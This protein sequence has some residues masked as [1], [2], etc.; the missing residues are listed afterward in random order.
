MKVLIGNGNQEF[1]KL[2]RDKF[3]DVT[4]EAGGSK[5]E[6]IEQVR[7]AD[8]YFGMPLREVFVA[9]E[10]LRWVQNPG[11][12]IDRMAKVPEMVDSDVVLTNCRGPHADPMADHVIGMMLGLT[13]RFG[14]LWD[15]QKAHRWDPGKYGSTYVELS[16]R[17][18]GI[19]A[20]GDIGMAVAR[21]AHG[22]GMKVYAVDKHP[23]P[24]SAEVESVWGLER[25]DRLISM[26]DWFVVT[27]P[28]TDETRGLIDKRR[29]GLLKDGA[30]IIVISRGNIIDEDALIDGLRSG[31]I[32]GAGLDVMA[33]EPLPAD[34]PLWDLDNVLLSP[35]SSANT[36]EMGQG[37]RRIFMENLRRFL[38]NEPFLYVCDKRAGF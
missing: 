22:F 33:E 7:D 15:D 14:D 12:G 26:S 27:A 9:G 17:T 4:F 38:A 6:Q 18:M 20:L 28:L 30:Y 34:S 36:P 35:H 29:M 3:P 23:A 8:V 21:R 32:A 16:G 10:R 5:E 37:R 25:L 2:L 19:L 13:H 31:R 11:T 1:A 24:T